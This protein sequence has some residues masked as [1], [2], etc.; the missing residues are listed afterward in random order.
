MIF[1]DRVTVL[2]GEEGEDALGNTIWIWTPHVVP[3]IVW[4]LDTSEA[5]QQGAQTVTSRYRIALKAGVAEIP[6][7]PSAIKLSWG[8]YQYSSSDP[9][10]GMT[11]D[12]AVE[13]HY[14]Q[15]RLHHYELTSADVI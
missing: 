4:P 10:S 9:T 2:I 8:P 6:T 3:A 5:I 12:G 1:R 11:V 15:G 13:R 14:V 7:N